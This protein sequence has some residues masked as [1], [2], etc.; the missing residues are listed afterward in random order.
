[1]RLILLGAPGSGK[2]TQA[3][4]ISAALGIPAVSTGNLL[5]EAIRTGSDAGQKAKSYMDRGALVPDEIT[6][7][8][9]NARLSQPD[10]RNGYIL[11][12]FPRNIPQA[13]ILEQAGVEIDAA[14]SLEVADE[15]IQRRMS[16][17]RV[18]PKCG[19][20]Y[21]LK[22]HPPVKPEMCDACGEP[23]VQR[24]DDAPETVLARLKTYHETTEPI[25][26]FYKARGKL[27]LIPAEDAIDAITDRVLDALGCAR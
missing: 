14:V 10:C 27:K 26:E 7:G 9:L 2:G 8:I 25:K 13:E 4:R 21:H 19:A 16:G 22:Y 5:R 24:S 1:M 6:V 3:E 18:C 17:R 20:S 11:D 15:Q 23:L 12:G